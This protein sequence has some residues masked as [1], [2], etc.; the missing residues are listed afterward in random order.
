MVRVF[1]ADC[2]AC[3][4]VARIAVAGN[5]SAPVP[6][7]NLIILEEHLKERIDRYTIPHMLS[8]QLLKLTNNLPRIPPQN[9][10]NEPPNLPPR[11]QMLLGLIQRQRELLLVDAADEEEEDEILVFVLV[12]EE[13]VEHREAAGRAVGGVARLVQVRQEGVAQV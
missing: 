11:Q 10:P 8:Q 1:R 3:F 7:L 4:G 13:E 6:P 2:A 5:P 12:G 9:G